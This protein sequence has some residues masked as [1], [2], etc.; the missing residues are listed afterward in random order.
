MAFLH[1][2]VGN[3]HKILVHTDIG[4]CS[5]FRS[6]GCKFAVYHS[7]QWIEIWCSRRP[8][9]YSEL[10]H[11]QTVRDDTSFM[12]WCIIL[13]CGSKL[14]LPS[15]YHST[16]SPNFYCPISSKVQIKCCAFRDASGYLRYCCLYKEIDLQNSMRSGTCV[17][18]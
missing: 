10:S 5:C 11:S 3:I 2:G 4:S 1:K 13:S 16:F 15:E 9:E 6:V 8:L 17:T 18:L 12:T 7:P 14:T